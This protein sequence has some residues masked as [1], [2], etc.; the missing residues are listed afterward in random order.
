MCGL[1]EDPFVEGALEGFE[2]Q[3]GVEDGVVV[4]DGGC[5]DA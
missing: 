1:G 5:G 3:G 2:G 4:E